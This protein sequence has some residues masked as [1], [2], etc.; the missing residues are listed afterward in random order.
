[1]E[2]DE[3]VEE[4]VEEEEGVREEEMEVEVVDHQVSISN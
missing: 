3:E 1:V 2:E 4:I